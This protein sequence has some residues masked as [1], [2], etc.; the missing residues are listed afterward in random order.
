MKPLSLRK[1]FIRFD[2]ELAEKG[3]PPLTK[4]WRDGIGTWL[5]AYEKGQVLELWAAV[6]RGAAKST[7]LYKLALFFA[8]FGDFAIPPGERHFAIVLSRLKEEAGKGVSI[9]DQWLTLLG[10]PHH[11]AGDVIELEDQPRGMRVVAASVAAASGWRAFFVGRDERSKWPVSGVDEREATEIDASA[12]AMTATHELA[13]TVSF[14]SAWGAFGAFY[15]NVTSGTDASKVVLGPTPTWI[16]APHITEASTRR[17]ERDPNKW[18]REYACVF[19]ETTEESLFSV[20]LIDRARRKDLDDVDPAECSE[21]VAAM[22][23]SLGRNAWTLT[24]AGRRDVGGRRK[25]SILLA[26]EWRAPA[27]GHFDMVDMLTK[28]AT[29]VRPYTREVLTDQFHGETL[30]AVANRLDLGLDI[31]VDKCTATEKLERYESLLTRL[32]DDEIDL[33]PDRKLRADLLSVKRRFSQN[34]FS[35]ELPT[36]ADGR[37]AD[38]APSVTL[39]LSRLQ[40]AAGWEAAMDAIQRRGGKLWD[41]DP[42]P[43]SS[44]DGG[45]FQ[46]VGPNGEPMPKIR[47]VSEDALEEW[48][49]Q[50]SFSPGI[51]HAHQLNRDVRGRFLEYVHSDYIGR[52]RW[53]PGD[54]LAEVRFEGDRAL[55]LAI[56]NLWKK[57]GLGPNGRWA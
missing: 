50:E 44:E 46:H 3:V 57:R 42:E 22:D 52:A 32:S 10:V 25:A 49:E 4:W 1:R 43:E 2:D 24:I 18:A 38:Y 11:M 5:D 55:R 16:A 45:L 33:H 12:V 30:Q 28:I 29:V 39:A 20:S 6:G 40:A 51:R 53:A 34:G 35:I 17:K 13:P 26:R 19:Q 14:G 23:P 8:L 37:H 21:I 41:D 31:T 48:R 47:P 36:T 27:G 56:S 7:A 9:V 15:E 54:T